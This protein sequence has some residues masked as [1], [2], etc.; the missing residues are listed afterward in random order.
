MLYYQYKKERYKT[1]K[2]M[3]YNT[4]VT[5]MLIVTIFGGVRIARLINI[6]NNNY[7]REGVV[8]AIDTSNEEVI[9]V[10]TTSNEWRFY[11]VGYE[12]GD[13]VTM[14]M[15]NN[16]TVTMTMDNIINDDIIKNVT[17]NTY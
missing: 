3:M 11:G 2:R 7:T 9:I 13:T 16:N 4:M 8:V 12:E 1:M 5:I 14:T 10:D 15:D 6:N 17:I